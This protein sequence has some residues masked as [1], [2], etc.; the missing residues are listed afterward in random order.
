[1][2]KRIIFDLDDTL[3]KWK[4]EY[5]ASFDRVLERINYNYDTHFIQKLIAAIEN[6][7]KIYS[8]F[9]KDD[10]LHLLNKN[11]ERPLPNNFIDYWLEEL[12]LC[13]EQASDDLIK[14]LNYLHNKYDLVVLTNWF[15]VSQVNRLKKAGIASYFSEV[16]CADKFPIKPNPES[17]LTAVGDYQISDCIMIG[18]SVDCDIDGALK[19]GLRAILYNPKNHNVNGDYQVITKLDNLI[20]IL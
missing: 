19:I 5:W 20:E 16:Y 4:S 7:E 11:I 1:M 6:Y 13:S 2:I 18:D 17:Y 15:T 12:S 3:I 10:M 9:N 8:V 14:T